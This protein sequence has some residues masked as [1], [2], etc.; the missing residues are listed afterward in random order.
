MKTSNKLILAA[1]LLVLIS[2]FGYDYLL[3]EA[4]VSGRYKDPYRDFATLKFKNFDTVD[5]VSST[6]ANVKFVQGPFSVRI[7]TNFLSYAKVYKLTP[8]SN[9]ITCIIQTP[10]YW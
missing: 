4:Y 10:I 6:A 9:T 7:D 5:I 1:L 3:K 2:L 8:F